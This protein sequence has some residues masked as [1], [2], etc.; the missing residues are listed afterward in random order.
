MI[1]TVGTKNEQVRVEWIEKTL[2]KI[3]AGLT[4][5]DAGA[6]ESQFN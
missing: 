3:P 2:Q 6:G 5:L 1:F 4:I